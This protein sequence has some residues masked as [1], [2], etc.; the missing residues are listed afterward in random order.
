[1]QDVDQTDFRYIHPLLFALFLS[2]LPGP[3][4]LRRVLTQSWVG[5]WAGWT[6]SYT[7][8]DNAVSSQEENGLAEEY[9]V[10]FARICADNVELLFD[11]DQERRRSLAREG[12]RVG[13]GDAHGA[14]NACL[15]D[16]L[17]QVLMWHDVNV[18]PVFA[19]GN[20]E[21]VAT[22]CLSG[23]SCTFV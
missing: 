16:C 23:C 2:M 19:D 7:L 15:A 5:E 4:E 11:I 13:T 18:K 1:M 14:N 20:A 12:L 17:L 9:V 22:R 10:R 6:E 21:I 8:L 3:G